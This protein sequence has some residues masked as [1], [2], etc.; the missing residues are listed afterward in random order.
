MACS[1]YSLGSAVVSG[2]GGGGGAMTAVEVV[3]LD[4]TGLDSASLSLGSNA[5]T[6]GGSAFATVVYGRASNPGGTATAGPAGITIVGD[7][8][9]TG[10]YGYVELDWS[11]L[12]SGWDADWLETGYG[13]IVELVGIVG[14]YTSSSDNI[15]LE[16]GQIAGTGDGVRFYYASA[17]THSF[18]ARRDS[19]DALVTASTPLQAGDSVSVK[20]LLL[21]GQ[22]GYAAHAVGSSPTVDLNAPTSGLQKTGASYSATSTRRY[23]ASGAA[24]VA[25]AMAGRRATYT[26]TAL[27]VYRLEVA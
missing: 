3:N 22:V 7:P 21:G 10:G 5:L 14:S 12:V 9:S 27:R 26:W 25:T 2:G 4:L 18:W 11:A 19:S 6:K 15:T 23:G 13:V 1:L 24:V 8:A 17:T 16:L 20:V